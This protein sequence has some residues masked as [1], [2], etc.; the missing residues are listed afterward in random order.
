[1]MVSLVGPNHARLI[2]ACMDGLKL[3]IRMSVC[4]EIL[5]ENEETLHYI[6]SILLSSPLH[7]SP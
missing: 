1:M 3:C 2:Y 4:R 6:A 5:P 7:E